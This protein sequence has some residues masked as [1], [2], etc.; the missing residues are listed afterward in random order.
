M[1]DWKHP[2]NRVLVAQKNVGDL[3]G[4]WRINRDATLFFRRLKKQGTE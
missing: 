2:V 1:Q 3:L 4:L